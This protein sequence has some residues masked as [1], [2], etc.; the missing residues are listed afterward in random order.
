VGK[1]DVILMEPRIQYTSTSMLACLLEICL[2]QFMPSKPVGISRR[3]G[4]SILALLTVF[5]SF[6]ASC[7]SHSSTQELESEAP[8]VLLV[9][10]GD[11]G[12]YATEIL[13]RVREGAEGYR[14][15]SKSYLVELHVTGSGEVALMDVPGHSVLGSTLSGLRSEGLPRIGVVASD[16]VVTVSLT[17]LGLHFGVPPGLETIAG[18][19]GAIIAVGESDRWGTFWRAVRVLNAAGIKRISYCSP[20][21]TLSQSS[22]PAQD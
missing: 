22:P 10:T 5:L 18:A 3:Q 11:E 15:R 13:D 14:G 2:G 12:V 19:E 1:N 20:P 16:G 4:N 8:M 7:G 6:L 17:E 9:V 21:L